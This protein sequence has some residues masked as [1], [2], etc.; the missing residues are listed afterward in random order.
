[1]QLLRFNQYLHFFIH[2]L[3][4]FAVK[5]KKEE[6]EKG[7]LGR[8]GRACRAQ[9]KRVGQRWV[10]CCQIAQAAQRPSEPRCPCMWSARQR[11]PLL[12]CSR[13]SPWPY[14]WWW[15]CRRRLHHHHFPVFTRGGG[16]GCHGNQPPPQPLYPSLPVFFPPSLSLSTCSPLARI[17]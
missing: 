4:N 8:V 11:R 7:R 13:S 1:M 14:W 2:V 10:L 16:G 12:I 17:R 6:N 9:D 15:W 5:V 3:F